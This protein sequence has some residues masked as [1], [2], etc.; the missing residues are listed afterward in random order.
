MVDEKG[1]KWPKWENV[2]RGTIGVAPPPGGGLG[3][4]GGGAIWRGYSQIFPSVAQNTWKGAHGKTCPPPGGGLVG[5]HTHRV[6]D[7]KRSSMLIVH[8][9]ES[10]MG[11]C[12][13]GKLWSM[14]GYD[15]PAQQQIQHEGT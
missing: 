9:W 1:R 13:L 12:E 5:E 7:F 10:K 11:R 8:I 14:L 2:T 4:I 15:K 6:R 3:A